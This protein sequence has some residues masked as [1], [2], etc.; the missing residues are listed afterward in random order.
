MGV[1]SSTSLS[2]LRENAVLLQ[3]VGEGTLQDEDEL[4][5]KLLTFSYSPTKDSM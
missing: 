1:A 3:F 4:W 2:K 5:D